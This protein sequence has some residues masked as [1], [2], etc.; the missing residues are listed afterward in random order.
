M[1]KKNLSEGYSSIF[2]VSVNNPENFG[3]I[4]FDN[5]NQITRIIEKPK[6]PKSN[7]IVS[8]LYFYTNDVIKFAKNLK[9][10][11]RGEKEITDVNN[12]FLSLNKLRLNILGANISWVD[13]GTYSSL[14]QAS[15]YFENI[16][17]KT[18]QKVACIE[19]IAFKMGF[20][21]KF[22]LQ[23]IAKSMINSAYGKYLLNLIENEI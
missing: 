21:N 13:T 15:K 14:I 16:E 3:V 4:E 9:K 19:E 22:Q 2:G 23:K 17:N 20:I 7:M 18:N 6:K 11:T 10:S 12:Y 1:P 5:Y 8:G